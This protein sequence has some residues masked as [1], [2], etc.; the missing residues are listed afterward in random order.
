[1]EHHASQMRHFGCE[2]D[3]RPRANTL[4]KQHDFA[5]WNALLQEPLIA[6]PDVGQGAGDAWGARAM[7]I[8]AVVVRQ[9]I[10]LQVPG[11]LIAEEQH[12]S[13][14]NCIAMAEQHCKGT[15]PLV[16]Q[17]GRADF[18]CTAGAPTAS[19]QVL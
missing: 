11:Q 12:S 13:Q 10:A 18:S 5:G 19:L 9:D 1:M 17:P 8:P 15:L 6:E 16:R 14:I 4:T 7:T 3:C 2:V